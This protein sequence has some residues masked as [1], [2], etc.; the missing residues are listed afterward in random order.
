MNYEADLFIKACSDSNGYSCR[1]YSDGT[2]MTNW[3]R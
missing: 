2:H 1:C 3:E